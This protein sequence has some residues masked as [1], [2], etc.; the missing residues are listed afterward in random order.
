MVLPANPIPAAQTGTASPVGLTARWMAAERA[1]ESRAPAPLF[2]DLYAPSLAGPE[3]EA[4]RTRM[5][6]AMGPMSLARDGEAEPYLSLRTRFFDD[7][8][9]AAVGECA[10]RQVVL[11]AAGM[12]A[13]AF[14]LPWPAGTTLYEVDRDDVF[15]HKEAVL[16][17]LGASAGCARRSVRA[18]LAGEWAPALLAT[19]FDPALPAA[20]LVEGLLVYLDAAA[21]ANLLQ[22]IG[23]IAAP[24]SWLGLDLVNSAWLQAPHARGY[25]AALRTAGCPWRFAV[26]DPEG[27]LAAYGWQARALQPGETGYRRWPLPVSRGAAS[28]RSFL[29]TATRR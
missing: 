8:L 28:P 12:D 29:V 5:H 24:G 14:R 7:W 16:A 25:M 27:W 21:V 11:L 2:H 6:G 15:D 1:L 23:N 4:L 26:D 13:R 10:I 18:D 3:G 20:V 17:G 19:G 22:T 9:R